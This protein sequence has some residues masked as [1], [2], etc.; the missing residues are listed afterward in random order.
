MPHYFV[1]THFATFIIGGL[2]DKKL[3]IISDFFPH[4]DFPVAVPLNFISSGFFHARVLVVLE[5][6]VF[7]HAPDKLRLI[8]IGSLAQQQMIS[9]LWQQCGS[10]VVPK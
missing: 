2:G 5:K 7:F 3:N 9:N 4:N 6:R 10:F 8:A 1:H